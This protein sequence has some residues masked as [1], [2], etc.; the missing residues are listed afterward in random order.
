VDEKAGVPD[1][2]P[3]VDIETDDETDALEDSVVVTVE[4]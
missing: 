1:I 2:D 3:V 4:V